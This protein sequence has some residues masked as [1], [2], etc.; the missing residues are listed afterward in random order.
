MGNNIRS[1]GRIL[2]QL[3]YVLN[4]KQK[5][6]A[7]KVFLCMISASMLELL[8]V[9]AI[10]PFLQMI[11]NPEALKSKWYIAWIFTSYPNVTNIDILLI[12]G[13]A[14]I[15][16]YL[17]KN[18]LMIFIAYVQ[19]S[20]AAEFQR[21]ISVRMLNSYLKRPYQY[22][23]NINSSIVIRGIN[24]DVSGVYQIL[25]NIFTM[26]SEV[27]TVSALGIFL[28]VTDWTIAVSAMLL[29]GV[30]FFAI[31]ICFKGKMKS[32]GKDMRAAA[33]L[34]YQYGYQAINGIKEITV[35]GRREKFVEQYN[36][37][38]LLERKSTIVNGFISA[39]PDRIL[40]GVCIGGFMGI[41]CIK[42]AMGTDLDTFIPVLGTFA[43]GAFR[44]L[45]SISKI[46]SRINAIVFYQPTLQNVY[47]NLRE[48]KS[49]EHLLEESGVDT[50]KQEQ[51][52][53]LRS[54]S[55]R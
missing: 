39:C 1:L 8:G 53:N 34:K 4:K 18:S 10:F 28:L 38:A 7:V 29:A 45:P 13:I 20:F 25:L 5:R 24:G 55:L 27:L 6:W 37:A 44:I 14:I 21:E 48:V 33:A 42:I 36:K 51:G 22:F 50:F 46:S 47:D 52:E 12:V 19:S 40:E 41:V 30:C 35:L 3:N 11:L 31:I 17:F 43:M 16:L 32:A 26:F 9:S 54:L 49:Y 15:F 2:N 23:L